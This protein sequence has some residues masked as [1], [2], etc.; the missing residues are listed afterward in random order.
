MLVSRPSHPYDIDALRS[1]V[2]GHFGAVTRWDQI[3]E[4]LI[5]EGRTS[6]V[7]VAQSLHLN[8]GSIVATD[9]GYN[10]YALFSKWTAGGVLFVTRLKDNAACEVV[11]AATGP[12]PCN[13]LAD[14]TIRLTGERRL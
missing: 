14:E 10:D 3:A 9:R 1:D 5:T 12:L 8:A 13:I 6:D 7:R 4:R 11:E 2:K